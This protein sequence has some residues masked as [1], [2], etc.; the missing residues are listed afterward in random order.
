MELGPLPR[1]LPGTVGGGPWCERGAG[2]V[3]VS[4]DALNRTAAALG[5][6][7]VTVV[8]LTGSWR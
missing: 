7:V 3:V 4:H 1:S 2:V 6:G 5:R 8:P